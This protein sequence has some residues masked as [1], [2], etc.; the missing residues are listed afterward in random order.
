MLHMK[1]INVIMCW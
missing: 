1:D